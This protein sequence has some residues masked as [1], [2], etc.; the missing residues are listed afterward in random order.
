MALGYTDANGVWQYGEDDEIPTL[1]AFMN[2]G[3]AAQSVSFNGV[4]S[5]LAAVE[6]AVPVPVLTARFTA[7]QS[8]VNGSVIGSGTWTAVPAYSSTGASTLW[9]PITNGFTFKVK[10]T[11]QINLN[12]KS[13]SGSY[14]G[15]TFCDLVVSGDPVPQRLS[16][17]PAGEDTFTGSAQVTI[18]NPNTPVTLAFYQLSGS[19]KSFS[20]SVNITRIGAFS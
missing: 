2:K 9:T 5:R 15:R 1:S 11:Y 13:V 3:Q 12:L 7:A 8:V 18:I 16:W 10:G 17:S 20:E 14:T 6:A 19:T 4:R